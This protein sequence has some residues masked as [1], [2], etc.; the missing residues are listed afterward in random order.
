MSQHLQET[1]EWRLL[2]RL[3]L[4]VTPK[5]PSHQE[6]IS[7]GRSHGSDAQSQF[8]SKTVELEACQAVLFCLFR[9]ALDAP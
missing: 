6:T 4:Q 5:S 3:P 2:A 7:A 8:A 9:H 1:G